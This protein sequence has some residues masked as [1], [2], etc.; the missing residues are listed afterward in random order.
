MGRLES[1]RTPADLADLTYEQLE[2]LAGEIRA[3]LIEAVSKTG[4]HLGPNLGVVEL[5]IAVHRTFSS[6]NDTILWDTGHQAYVHKILTGRLAGFSR[7][8]QRGGLSGYPNRD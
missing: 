4:G 3:F 7:L 5:S 8:R 2:R 1:L 6:P